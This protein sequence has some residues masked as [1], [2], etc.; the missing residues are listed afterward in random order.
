MR[1]IPLRVGVRVG[2]HP[3]HRQHGCDKDDTRHDIGPGVLH[4][5]GLATRKTSVISLQCICIENNVEGKTEQEIKLVFDH[6]SQMNRDYDHDS[7]VYD[8]I[9]KSVAERDISI[10]R[11]ARDMGWDLFAPLTRDK[12][13]QI[14]EEVEDSCCCCCCCCCCLTFRRGLPIWE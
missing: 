11:L 10:K 5:V 8:D 9:Q 4:V 13:F 2:S 3:L 1:Q 6:W 12:C 14:G 7:L